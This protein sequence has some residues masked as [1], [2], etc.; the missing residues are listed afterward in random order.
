[1]QHRAARNDQHVTESRPCDDTDD[2][3]NAFL[4]RCVEPPEEGQKGEGVL[5]CRTSGFVLAPATRARWIA[6]AAHRRAQKFRKPS[7]QDDGGAF[8]EA[9]AAT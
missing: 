6:R 8:G 2:V 9:F 3:W 1:L 7:P 4:L 5:A